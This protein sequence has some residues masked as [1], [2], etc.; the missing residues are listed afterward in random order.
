M[1]QHYHRDCVDASDLKAW[2]SHYS[3]LGYAT[4][5]KGNRLYY[6]VNDINYSA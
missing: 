2:Q 1:D 4:Y 6:F 5:V 3:E